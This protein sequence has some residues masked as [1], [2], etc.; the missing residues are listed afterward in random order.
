MFINDL[1][2]THTLPQKLIVT[3]RF[4]AR[5]MYAPPLH[6]PEFTIAM[7]AMMLDCMSP[8]ISF[9]QSFDHANNWYGA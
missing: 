6:L 5:C 2:N 1:A 9:L 4:I 8:N 3:C 7:A